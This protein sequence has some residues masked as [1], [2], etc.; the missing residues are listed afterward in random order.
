MENS[1]RIIL[2]YK[3]IYKPIMQF[4]KNKTASIHQWYPFVE[5]Y[6][7]EF[8]SGIISELDYNPNNA[9]DPFVGSGTTAIELQNLGIKCNS[10]EVSPFMYLL[11]TTKMT[12]NYKLKEFDSCLHHIEKELECPKPNIKDYIFPPAYKTIEEKKG[13]KRGYFSNE[14]MTALLNIK[15]ALTKINPKYFNLFTIAFASI[16]LEV[17]NVYRNGKCLSYKRENS[18]T[19]GATESDVYKKYLNRI[20]DIIRPDV[21]AIE[22]FKYQIKNRD[23]CK[24]GD[25][26]TNIKTLRNNSIDL[27]ITS[28]PYL[29]SRDYTDIYMAELW[30]LDLVKNYDDVR[31]LRNQSFRSHVQI[32]HGSLKTLDISILKDAVSR[33]EAN[34]SEHWNTEI[35][36]MIKGYF[37]DMDIIFN[38]LKSK[39][40]RDKKIFFNVANS[41]YYGVEIKVDEIICEI[42]EQRGFKVDCIREARLLNPSSQQKNK[43]SSLRESVIV[44]NS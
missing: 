12:V 11:A 9:L 10:F 44:I 27:V 23:Y 3:A 17:S 41:A 19:L 39:M 7:R 20:Y 40:V 24:F 30:M 15:Y 16:L 4:N 43:I 5:G 31:K 13:T 18:P 25:V 37:I 21:S 38:S 33:L 28:P 22:N 36:S 34:F 26:R 14:V 2:D 1:E 6:S 29:N 42:A 8:I 35:L 32:K